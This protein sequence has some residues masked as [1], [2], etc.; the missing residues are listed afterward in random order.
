MQDARALAEKAS[1]A[2]GE[3]PPPGLLCR[4]RRCLQLLA[5]RAALA[6]FPPPA[7]PPAAAAP[8][9]AAAAAEAAAADTDAD[10][11]PAARPDANPTDYE[12]PEGTGAG[13]LDA[14]GGAGAGEESG[15]RG[16][17]PGDG[18]AAQAQPE[19]AVAAA[20]VA[21]AWAALAR[22]V[23]EL[24]GRPSREELTVAVRGLLEAGDVVRRA[25]F[26]GGVPNPC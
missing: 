9:A 25:G 3:G 23:D 8:W 18:E 20:E 26:A 17:Q 1:G 16:L 5:A 7:P 2:A 13:M 24:A 19:Q 6:G 11:G 22:D 14:V 21:H 4:F 15:E 10:A 12:V